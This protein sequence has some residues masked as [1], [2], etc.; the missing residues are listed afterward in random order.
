MIISLDLDGTLLD[1]N[2]KLPQ[3]TME[4]LNELKQK[5]EI[6]VINSGRALKDALPVT[7]NAYF[8]NYVI[9]DTGAVIYEVETNKV[10]MEVGISK[11]D[12]YHLF[13]AVSSSDMMFYVHM[14]DYRYAYPY[15]FKTYETIMNDHRNILHI[16]IDFKNQEDVE[17][18]INENKNNFPHLKIFAMVDSFGT[19]KWIEIINKKAG[20]YKTLL[21]LIKILNMKKEDIISFGDAINDLELIR[22]SRIG[23]AM[24]NAIPELKQNAK[25]VTEFSNDEYGVEKWL[26]EFYKN[27][28]IQ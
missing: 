3:S 7:E 4:Y 16:S 5:G 21:E 20:K 24:K 28:G 8:A 10:I 22:N 12:G 1:A 14:E 19:D 9:S 11:E 25:V 18:F 23:V 15:N 17:K 27:G 2:R 26:K 13:K 6:I